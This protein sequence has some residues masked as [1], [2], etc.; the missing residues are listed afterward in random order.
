MLWLKRHPVLI[1]LAVATVLAISLIII[2]WPKGEN[3]P[4]AMTSSGNLTVQTG[5]DDDI[6][7]DPN[8]PLRCFVGAQMVGELPLEDC[9][10]RNGVSRGAMDV[11]LDPS[12]NLA[13]ANGP[14]DAISPLTVTAGDETTAATADALPQSPG[15]T[16]SHT[17]SPPS[18]APD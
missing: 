2:V 13:A 14:G 15:S 1:A 11:G 4:A 7:L 16:E 6:K 5:R 10:R 12:G 3:Y 18:P 17:G 9:A 8:K